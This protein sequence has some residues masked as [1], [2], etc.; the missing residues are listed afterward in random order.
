MQVLAVMM[1]SCSIILR[2][3]VEHIN[4]GESQLTPDVGPKMHSSS[5]IIYPHA[6]MSLALYM[7]NMLVRDVYDLL[8]DSNLLWP[9]LKHSYK[10]NA[11]SFRKNAQL[12]VA[13]DVTRIALDRQID[14]CF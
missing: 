2:I 4:S 14:S 11:V 10:I 1:T 13:L 8:N 3:T 12:L 5:V 9:G 6:D 7:F